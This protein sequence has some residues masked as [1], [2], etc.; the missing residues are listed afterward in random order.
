[1]SV[2]AV[3][4]RDG[5][6]RR[7]RD[8]A[9]VHRVRWR[10][11]TGQARSK[12]VGKRRDAEAFDAKLKEARRLG[13]L[14]LLEAGRETLDE[15]VEGT[16]AVTHAAHL[17][18]KTRSL[19]AY[20]YDVHIAPR[21]GSTALRDLNPEVIARWHADVLAGG[22]GPVA[23][24]KALKLLGGIL[25]RAAEARRI[26]YNPARLVRK[27]LL[28]PAEEVRPLAPETVERIRG[29]LG[30][31]SP[32]RGPVDLAHRDAIL[33]SLLAYAGLRPQE[34]IGLRWGDVRERTL[35]I[36]APK[37]RRSRPSRTVRVLAPLRADLAAWR[38][39]CGRPS[40]RQ[41]VVLGADG[42]AWTG[43]GYAQWRGK[44]WAKA[45]DALELE[46]AT[47]Y[48]LRHSFASLLLHEGRSVIYVARQ[49]GH[50]AQLTM[51]TYGHVIDEL[52]DAPH[53]AA[54]DAIRQAR[55]RLSVGKVSADEVPCR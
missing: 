19:Y 13:S 22:A 12:V 36:Y 42:A 45:L 7:D 46:R 55:E 21:L 23:A 14:G 26:P 37:T 51:R 17:A 40:D 11:E 2:E 50:G 48:A 53:L 16:W 31:R 32:G 35:L 25:Q 1:M 39:A 38:L 15:Y 33:V 18:P 4:N 44:T 54:E 5:A 29:R 41:P 28:P 3:R 24:E 6:L 49:L 52:E 34:A 47:P 9:I 30:A 10:D 8:G 27:P 43:D 20:L